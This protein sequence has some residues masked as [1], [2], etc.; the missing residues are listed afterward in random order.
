MDVTELLAV[1][2]TQMRIPLVVV[3]LALLSAGSK[4]YGKLGDGKV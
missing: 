1:R 4:A 2:L 3:V